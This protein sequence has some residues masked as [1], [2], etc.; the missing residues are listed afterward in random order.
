MKEEMRN[1]GI[2]IARQMFCRIVSDVPDIPR[3]LAVALVSKALG[4]SAL[5]VG[6][7]IGLTNVLCW[8]PPATSSRVPKED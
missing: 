1:K 8:K 7:D 2:T 5:D 6:F 3:Y 4:R